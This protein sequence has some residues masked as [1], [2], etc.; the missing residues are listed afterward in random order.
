M[1]ISGETALV[2]MQQNTIDDNLTFWWWLGA[3][4]PHSITGANVNPDL[5]HHMESLGL[6]ELN[7]F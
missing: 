3:I 1:S 2:L 7:N 6:N 4:R 5:L